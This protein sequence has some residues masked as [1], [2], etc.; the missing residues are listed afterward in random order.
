MAM[1]RVEIDIKIKYH[2]DMIEVCKASERKGHLDKLRYYEKRDEISAKYKEA[3]KTCG[4]KKRLSSADYYQKNRDE[5]TLARRQ[6]EALKKKN[7]PE[8][9]EKERAR[10]REYKKKNKEKLRIKLNEYRAKNREKVSLAQRVYRK[11]SP[12]LLKLYVS[13]SPEYKKRIREKYKERAS[14]L[15]KKY[16]LENRERV[17]WSNHKRLQHIKQATIGG[18]RWKSEIQAIYKERIQRDEETGID[19]HVDHL[20]PLRGKEVCGLHVPWNL[21]IIT[22]SENL[23]KSNKNSVFL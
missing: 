15:A 6:A 13:A 8:Y 20:S 23:E 22:K 3:Y 4:D 9:A 21:K 10:L 2:K 14:V 18:D 17:I 11:K 1:S 7:N 12:E 5:I 19:H 16:R